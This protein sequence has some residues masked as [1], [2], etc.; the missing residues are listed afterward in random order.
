MGQNSKNNVHPCLS[1]GACC[2][3]FR[4]S[5]S[6]SETSIKKTTTNINLSRVSSEAVNFDFN[7]YKC[8]SKA[9]SFNV[10]S[11]L[12]E[13]SGSTIC[14]MKGT[15][16]K[17]RPSCVAFVGKVGGAASCSIYENRPSPCRDFTASYEDGK[18]HPRCDEARRKHGLRPLGREA[19]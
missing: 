14:S 3:Y 17:H 8:E 10:P 7:R 1:C 4:V 13:L 9:N 12:V 5:F 18:H 15:T 6:V 2:A 16:H 11:E 19:Y